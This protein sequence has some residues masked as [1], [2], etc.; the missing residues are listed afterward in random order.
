M[1]CFWGLRVI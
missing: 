1:L